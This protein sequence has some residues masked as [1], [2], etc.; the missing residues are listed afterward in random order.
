M[1]CVC[2]LY[3]TMTHKALLGKA[4]DPAFLQ[5]YGILFWKTVFIQSISAEVEIQLLTDLVFWKARLCAHAKQISLGLVPTLYPQEKW[6]G[7]AYILMAQMP[8]SKYDAHIYPAYQEESVVHA[9]SRTVGK[10]GT[11]VQDLTGRGLSHCTNAARSMQVTKLCEWLKDGVGAWN[12]LQSSF[13]D[14]L[15]WALLLTLWPLKHI[16]LPGLLLPAFLHVKKCF[17]NRQNFN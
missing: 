15:Y 4:L 11:G 9:I 17:T 10:H 6:S 7:M 1:D 12:P 14:L 8:A 16:G 13:P 3:I 2:E 5:A